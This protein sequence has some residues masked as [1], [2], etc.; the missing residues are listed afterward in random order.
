MKTRGR[1]FT[2]F[3]AIAAIAAANCISPQMAFGAH[4][5]ASS[6]A[7]TKLVQA[8]QDRAAHHGQ[9]DHNVRHAAEDTDAGAATGSGANDGR[10]KTCC[11]SMT[12]MTGAAIFAAPAIMISSSAAAIGAAPLDDALRAFNAAALDPPPRIG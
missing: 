1:N 8:S 2:V 4:H 11:S 3:L 10:A 7:G 9:A 5:P 12:C 6:K